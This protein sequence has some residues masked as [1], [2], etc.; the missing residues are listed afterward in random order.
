MFAKKKKFRETWKVVGIGQRE[1][2]IWKLKAFVFEAMQL[3]LR[4]VL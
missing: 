2:Q 4:N 1:N 3:L